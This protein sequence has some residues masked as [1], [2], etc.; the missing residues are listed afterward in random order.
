MPLHASELCPLCRGLG[1]IRFAAE[2]L[3]LDDVRV[4]RSCKAGDDLAVSIFNLAW[5]EEE[6][7]PSEA[8][9]F[10]DTATGK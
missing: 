4:C 5:S 2:P 3:I 8:L 7:V 10:K 1:V 9:S 6:R